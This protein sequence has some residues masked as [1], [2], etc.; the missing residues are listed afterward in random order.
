[1]KPS[2]LKRNQSSAT[3][4]PDISADADSGSSVVHTPEDAGFDL[5]SFRESEDG[6][7]L[8][9]WALNEFSKCRGFKTAKHR[10]WYTF[11]AF[12]FGHQWINILNQKMPGAESKP[13]AA[14]A[15]PPYV[16]RRTVNRIRSFVRT[17]QSKFLST[18]PTV[19][20]VPST[21][22][23]EDIRAAYAG[24]QIIE[25]YFSKRKLR[26]EY[27]KANWW[28]II[29][30]TG[31][32]KVWWD[33]TVTDPT[34]GQPGDIMYRSVTPYHIFVPDM[35]E[36][37]ID[38]QPYIIQAQ[39]KPL[40]WVRQQYGEELKGQDL[41][42]TQSSSN[43]LLDEAFYTLSNTHKSEL[44]AVVILEMWVKPGTHRLLPQG[45]LLI[46]AGEILVGAYTDG[47]P[48]AHG[49]YPYTKFEHLSNDTFFADSPLADLIELQKEF[50]EIRTQLSTAAKRMGSPQ[51]LAQQG[52]IVPG[53]IT[54][55]PGQI[56]QYRPG[57]PP[58]SPLPLQPIPEYVLNNLQQVVQDFEDL[59]GQHEVSK[60]S[61]PT[62]V[63][64]GTALA[65][66][67]ETDDNYLTPQYQNVEDGFERIAFQTL[68]L[69]QEFVDAPRL[70]KVI[71]ADGA[72]DSALLMGSDI[73]G[74]TDVRVEPG[75][76]IGQSQAA[77]R[78]AV[79]DMFAV[80]ILQDPNQ[81]LRLLEVGGAQKV[82]D[83][84][85]VAEKKAWRENTKMKSL[86]TEEGMA[87][88]QEH[89]QTNMQQ[90]LTDMAL[91]MSTEPDPVTGEMPT[92]PVDPAQ[93]MQ[94][95]E[96]RSFIQEQIPPLIP[97]DDFD[98]HEIHIDVHNRYRMGQEYETL[99]DEVKAEF[100]KHV[101]MH[102]ML[103]Q[104]KMMEQLMM[105]GGMPPVGPE[106]PDGPGGNAPVDG[107]GLT[108]QTGGP[109]IVG[110]APAQP[111]SI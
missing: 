88:L 4:S 82:L 85:S 22:E 74:A 25:S 84:I 48:Y 10:Q 34:S 92:E 27:S 91:S 46:L 62:G 97:A 40:E 102:E 101:Q 68:S 54:N 76:S 93:L 73:N 55:E 106:G 75:S 58:P 98:M 24:E 30:G 90:M 6:K 95:P 9:A 35:R 109:G 71:G 5:Y 72:F 38:D 21:S 36:Q 18:L 11:M 70:I 12:T 23:E 19:T 51:L 17:E 56:I 63:T 59:S 107:P 64:A 41:N 47:M 78:A 3:S 83:T 33:P 43:T 8:T 20:S 1:M 49:Q 31:I 81:A 69:F 61:T 100:D 7:T 110:P 52:S 26:R 87:M 14:K 103:L 77:K 57:T 42:P 13:I 105:G 60:G 96:V 16:S 32:L 108:P 104:K 53:R 2:P 94:N 86:K 28:K 65:F 80:G 89:V 39:V 29:T 66:L 37:E 50:N 79:M 15:A 44:D 45:G 111:A 67:K 99:P